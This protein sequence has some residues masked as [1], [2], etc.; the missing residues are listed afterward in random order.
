MQYYYF[1]IFLGVTLSLWANPL[2]PE[3]CPVSALFVWLLITGLFNKSLV[4]P[5]SV[6]WG[7][8]SL[9]MF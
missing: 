8:Q 6:C 4:L 3:L 2:K 7:I 9:F 5:F 1:F